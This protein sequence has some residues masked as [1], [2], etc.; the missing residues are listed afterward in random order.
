MAATDRSSQT[1]SDTVQRSSTISRAPSHPA[2]SKWNIFCAPPK[3]RLPAA[4]WD[5]A[6]HQAVRR[7]AASLHLRAHAVALGAIPDRRCAA[8][9]A[10]SVAAASAAAAATLL[11]ACRCSNMALEHAC[12]YELLAPPQHSLLLSVSSAAGL[13]AGSLSRTP[14]THRAAAP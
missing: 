1:V 14:P 2:A 13:A 3:R 7:G 9:A 6:Q 8:T 11:P 10:V 4:A 5:E 12:F